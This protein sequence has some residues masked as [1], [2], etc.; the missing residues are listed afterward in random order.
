[1]DADS[2]APKSRRARA[3]L[4]G[5]IPY[6]LKCVEEKFSEVHRSNLRPLAPDSVTN[7]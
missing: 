4:L 1:M 3:L 5:S 2:G 7:W 6:S